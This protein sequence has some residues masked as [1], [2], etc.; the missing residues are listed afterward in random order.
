MPLCVCGVCVCMCERTLTIVSMDKSLHFINTLIIIV[1]FNEFAY[2]MFQFL[3][4]QYEMRIATMEVAKST[5]EE[6]GS[7]Y[8][9]K[10]TELENR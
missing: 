6:V 9:K 5:K 2:V 8:K 3:N 4:T 10:H 1:V 7:E